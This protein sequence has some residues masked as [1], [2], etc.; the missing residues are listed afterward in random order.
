MPGKVRPAGTSYNPSAAEAK[1]S[2][3]PSVGKPV[4]FSTPP[5]NTT[6]YIPEA[7]AVMPSRKALPLLAQAF[8]IRVTGTGVMPN[9]SARMG[10]VCP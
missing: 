7:M 3:T 9:Q 5:T 4:I 1:T 6:S 10:A 2:V 8:S